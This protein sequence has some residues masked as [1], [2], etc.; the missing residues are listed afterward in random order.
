MTS[1]CVSRY[2]GPTCFA[3]PG[4]HDWFDGLFTYLELIVNRVRVWIGVRGEEVVGLWWGAPPL[5]VVGDSHGVLFATD[6]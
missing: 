6:Q 1:T 5:K 2:D 4:N 3:I